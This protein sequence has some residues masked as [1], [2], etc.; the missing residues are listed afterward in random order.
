MD[1]LGTFKKAGAE[2]NFYTVK[3]K[4]LYATIE[5]LADALGYQSKKGLEKLI[6]RNSYLRE[7]TY[8][9]LAP[10]PYAVGGS[11]QRKSGQR[12]TQVIRF[13][14]RQG[15]YEI[16]SL[17][18]MPKG[19]AI[20]AELFRYIEWLENQL[21]LATIKYIES[22]PLQNKLHETINKAPFYVKKYGEKVPAYIYMQFNALLSKLASRNRVNK[23]ESLTAF[24]LETLGNLEMFVCSLLAIGKDYKEI[25]PMVKEYSKNFFDM[26]EGA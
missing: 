18:T 1:L 25:S 15:I 21:R 3:R 2:V 13:F 4:E 16:F 11:A 26:A 6:K 17:S 24:E 9:F 8:S 10:A 23:K 19:R 14:T 22:K 20:R 5:Q 7:N 12:K